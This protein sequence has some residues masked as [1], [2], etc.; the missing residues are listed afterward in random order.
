MKLQKTNKVKT[1]PHAM[2]N[3]HK[4]SELT[5]HLY[6]AIEKRLIELTI[7]ACFGYPELK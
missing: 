5:Q 3:K 6:L 7:P 1:L 2:K 4:R